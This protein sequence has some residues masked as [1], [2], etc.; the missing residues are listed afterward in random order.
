MIGGRDGT[1]NVTR[2]FFE[3]KEHDASHGDVRLV[4]KVERKQER[5]RTSLIR[6]DPVLLVFSVRHLAVSGDFASLDFQEGSSDG[7][8][9]EVAL[10]TSDFGCDFIDCTLALIADCLV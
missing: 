6:S 4:R 7:G 9:N 5:R 3:L 1:L 8:S 2:R 10:E